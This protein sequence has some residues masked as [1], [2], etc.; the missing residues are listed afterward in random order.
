[1]LVENASPIVDSQDDH[2][3][4][5]KWRRWLVKFVDGTYFTSFTTTV[6][7]INVIVLSMEYYQQPKSWSDGLEMAN[8]VFTGIFTMECLLKIVAFGPIRYVKDSWNIFDSV[9][10]GFSI[11]ELFMDFGVI[12]PTIIRVFRIFR[13][14]RV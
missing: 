11:A 2:T 10:V 4:K 3:S 5:F 1:M 13:V 14:L 8:I 7:M 9:I 12:N 6:I